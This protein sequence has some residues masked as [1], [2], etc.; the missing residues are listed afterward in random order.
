[1]QELF[2]FSPYISIFLD[3][4]ITFT[5]I[6]IEYLEK[7]NQRLKKNGEIPYE[8]LEDDIEDNKIQENFTSCFRAC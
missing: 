1:M 5:D 4:F 8:I 2:K 6:N 7:L 3:C